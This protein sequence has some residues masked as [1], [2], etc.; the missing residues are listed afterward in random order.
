[1]QRRDG[2]WSWESFRPFGTRRD[3]PDRAYRDARACC[4]DAARGPTHRGRLCSPSHHVLAPPDRC[5]GRWIPCASVRLD[6]RSLVPVQA[7]C[8]PSTPR[9]LAS[10]G[11]RRLRQC[12][13]RICTTT[14]SRAAERCRFV[15]GAWA[16]SRQRRQAFPDRPTRRR[17]CTGM[18]F[19]AAE[20][21]RFAGGAAVRRVRGWAV[22]TATRRSGRRC[23]RTRSPRSPRL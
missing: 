3:G 7:S 17:I 4:A 5:V 23:R 8:S 19:T 18:P 1:M 2:S 6:C 10:T 15:G 14:P 21:C 9:H 20:R 13:W 22:R 12:T 16:R 11:M